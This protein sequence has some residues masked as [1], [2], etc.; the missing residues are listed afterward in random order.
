MRRYAL[1]PIA[2]LI[3]SSTAFAG[4]AEKMLAPT[5]SS[6]G[7]TLRWGSFEQAAS[8]VDPEYLKA[9]PLSNLDLQRYAQ[10]RVS[11]YHDDSPPQSIS[12]TDIMQLVEIG[13][14]NEHTQSERT[15]VDRQHWHWD[16]KAKKWWLVSG[17]PDI[18]HKD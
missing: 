10:V 13:I 11:F 1:V 18:T 2:L 5:L 12:P 7:S 3:A 15:I 4:K 14:V 16:A 6:Y 9:H 17:L 8:F